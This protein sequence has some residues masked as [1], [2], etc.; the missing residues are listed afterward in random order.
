[1]E[2]VVFN[3]HSPLANPEHAHLLLAGL[4][5]LE[6]FSFPAD[7]A[8]VA[9]CQDVF[10]VGFYGLAG[11]DTVGGGGLDGDVK[12][13]SGDL[14]FEDGAEFAAGG[15]GA[16]AVEEAGEGVD[17]LAIDEDVQAD[18]VCGAHVVG[19]VVE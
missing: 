11:D 9:L 7:V 16:G 5:F 2:G 10:A 3:G 14:F 18:E 19:L 13:L 15:V 1:M 17:G 8:T 6:E 12:L 4:L